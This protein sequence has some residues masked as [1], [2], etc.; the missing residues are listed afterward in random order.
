[1]CMP[2]P[3]GRAKRRAWLRRRLVVLR[4]QLERGFVEAWYRNHH[5][6]VAR[7]ERDCHAAINAARAELADLCDLPLLRKAG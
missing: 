7:Q 2:K 5:W 4:Q 6:T 3:R 1:M